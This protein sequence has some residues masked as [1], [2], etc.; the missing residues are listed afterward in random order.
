MPIDFPLKMCYN[1]YRT[2][3]REI[4][5]NSYVPNNQ[6]KSA[7]DVKTEKEVNYDTERFFHNNR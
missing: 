4:P 5:Q 3:E 1:K 7:V 2:K 6:F